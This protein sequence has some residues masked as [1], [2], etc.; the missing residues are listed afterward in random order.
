MVGA[1]EKP[2]EKGAEIDGILI[3]FLFRLPV[4]LLAAL[5]KDRV[6]HH[7]ACVYGETSPGKNGAYG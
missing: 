7:N 6:Q 2:P 1:A 5:Q 4:V 3:S